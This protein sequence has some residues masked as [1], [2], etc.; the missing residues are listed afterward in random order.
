[1]FAINSFPSPQQSIIFHHVLQHKSSRK[2]T[3]SQA[4]EVRRR[5]LSV[6]RG[7][8]S[9][10]SISRLIKV[11]RKWFT[12]GMNWQ[13]KRVKMTFWN[14]QD[15]WLSGKYQKW[16]RKSAWIVNVGSVVMRCNWTVEI[17]TRARWPKLLWRA[18]YQHFVCFFDVLMF[19]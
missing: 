6:N 3:S 17:T 2:L 16:V 4:R 18:K 15:V 9:W 7:M 10:E 19:H 1:M 14:Y 12:C 11:T 13:K 8:M 5:R